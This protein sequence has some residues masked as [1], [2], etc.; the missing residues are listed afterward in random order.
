MP[1]VLRLPLPQVGEGLPSGHVLAASRREVVSRPG[2]SLRS[3]LDHGLHFLEPSGRLV[4]PPPD[5]R[6]AFALLVVLRQPPRESR[7]QAIEGSELLLDLG[8]EFSDASG[9]LLNLCPQLP[10]A[11]LGR[12]ALSPGPSE[13]P[14]SL[15]EVIG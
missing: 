3:Q 9:Q 8:A 1:E 13:R 10:Y 4:R 14:Q 15:R 7:V 12:A 2:E 6:K 5:S 11:S